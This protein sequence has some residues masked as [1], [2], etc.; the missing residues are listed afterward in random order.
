MYHLRILN[1]LCQI[2]P[3]NKLMTLIG[4]IKTDVSNFQIRVVGKLHKLIF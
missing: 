3:I 2:G 1:L 4:E